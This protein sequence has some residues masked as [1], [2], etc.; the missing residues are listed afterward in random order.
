MK[1]LREYLPKNFYLRLLFAFLFWSVFQLILSYFLDNYNIVFS[2][3][4][5]LILTAVEYSSYHDDL[6]NGKIKL[7]E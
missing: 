3:I 1:P 2:S 7:D 5:S 4:F 6:A